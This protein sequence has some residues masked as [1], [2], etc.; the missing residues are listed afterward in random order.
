MSGATSRWARP[1][2]RVFGHPRPRQARVMYR[3]GF[4]CEEIRLTLGYRT[5]EAVR[6]ILQ[7]N[8]PAGRLR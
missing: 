5:R 4:N 3:D 1:G 8:Q 6:E 7:L 2:F